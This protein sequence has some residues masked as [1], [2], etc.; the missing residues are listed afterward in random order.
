MYVFMDISNNKFLAIFSK[1]ANFMHELQINFLFL[2]CLTLY[3]LEYIATLNS[4]AYMKYSYRLLNSVLV[5]I[6]P[7]LIMDYKGC[8]VLQH[9]S[10]CYYGN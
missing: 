4:T 8:K 6:I 5:P 2:V 10:K 7:L 3:H 9:Q 1:Y